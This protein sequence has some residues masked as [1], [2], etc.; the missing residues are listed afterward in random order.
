MDINTDPAFGFT[1]TTTTTINPNDYACVSG[2]L[3][4][5][6]G[7]YTFLFNIEDGGTFPLYGGP[8]EYFLYVLTAVFQ[9]SPVWC[10][11]N[12]NNGEPYIAVIGNTRPAPAYPWLE[13][14]WNVAGFVVNRGPC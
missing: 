2:P 3:T 10:L 11:T 4:F 1:T 12:D 7:T 8:N 6:N 9:Q 5:A 14:S 13:T